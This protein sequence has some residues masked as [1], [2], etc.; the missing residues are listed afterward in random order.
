MTNKVEPEDFFPVAL[1]KIFSGCEITGPLELSVEEIKEARAWK[2][3]LDL[4]IQE[5][6]NQ[7]TNFGL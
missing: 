5:I 2:R 3:Q 7:L 6:E 4:D 1:R